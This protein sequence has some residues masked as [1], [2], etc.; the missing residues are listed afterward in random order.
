[1]IDKPI[2]IKRD[3]KLA[4]RIQCSPYAHYRCTY[5]YDIYIQVYICIFTLH[6]PIIHGF[7]TLHLPSSLLNGLNIVVFTHS[8]LCGHIWFSVYILSS[9]SIPG[10]EIK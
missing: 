10:D 6:I 3:E 1:M 9:I 7:Y 5:V 8:M 2:S 4:S